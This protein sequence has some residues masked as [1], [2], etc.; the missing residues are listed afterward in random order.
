MVI[1]LLCVFT[2]CSNGESDS[3]TTVSTAAA[4]AQSTQTTTQPQ[5][6]AWEWQKDTP[7]NQGL[8]SS[9]LPDI[10]ATFDSFNLLSS[11]IVKKRLYCG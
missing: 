1:S 8:N 3:E 7:D 6:T 2:A 9:A 5:E 10:H 4:T 11:V